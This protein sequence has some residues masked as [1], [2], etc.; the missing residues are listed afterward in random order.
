MNKTLNAI[1]IIGLLANLFG[2]AKTLPLVSHAHVGHALTTWHDTPNQAGLYVSAQKEAREALEI[3]SRHLDGQ[4]SE[5]QYAIKQIAYLLNPDIAFLDDVEFGV[6]YGVIRALEGTL[7]HIEYAA[8]SDDASLNLVSSIN[9]ITKN[10]ETVINNFKKIFLGTQ[11][12]TNNT[13]ALMGQLHGDLD[14]AVN[15]KSDSGLVTVYGMRNFTDDFNKMLKRE[16]NPRYEPLPRKYVLG[17][18]RLP[19]GHWGYR[20]RDSSGY[21]GANSGGGNY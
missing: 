12:V 13:S 6:R 19:N 15:G 9:D 18:V 17:L 21:G 8:S 20:L 11:K 10:G 1:V 5:Q 14:L 3:A 2:C 4:P 7:D 16:Q